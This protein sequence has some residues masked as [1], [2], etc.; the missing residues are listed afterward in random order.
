MSRQ[1]AG[2]GA[3][4]WGPDPLWLLRHVGMGG[5]RTGVNFDDVGFVLE[6]AVPEGGV[7]V[8]VPEQGLA[9][10]VLRRGMVSMGFAAQRGCV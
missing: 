1:C 6:C 3:L 7:V 2:F 5:G 4:V 10:E 9:E 8:V